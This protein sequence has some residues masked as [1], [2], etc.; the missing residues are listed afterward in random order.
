MKKLICTWLCVLIFGIV[1]VPAYAERPKVDLR[2]G[3]GML[4]GDT[5]YQIGGKIDTPLGS[6]EVHFP[7]SELKFPLDVYMA[8]VGGSIEFAEKWKVNASV[9]KN[10]TSDTGM[11]EDS[12]WGVWYLGAELPHMP[13]Y[14]CN[15]AYCEPDS[16]DI[17]SESGADLDA[18][19]MD[20][21]LRYKFYEKSNWS[22]SAGLGYIHQNF[23]YEVSNL[24]QWYPSYYDYFGVGLPYDLVSGKVLTYEV[25]YSIPYIELATEF[26]IKDKF[27]VGASI[28]YSP[29]VNVKDE[30]NHILRSKI[31]KGDCDGNAILLSLDGQYD[32]TESWFLTL[33][34]NYT[35]VDADGKSKSYFDGEYSHTIDRKSESKQILTTFAV[36]YAF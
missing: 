34:F 15:P 29:F 9:K 27:S 14:Y 31:S 23:D 20:I 10:I 32:F 3:I 12:D 36:G 26:K 5:T 19:I 1:G 21:N 24:V 17:Y 8:S 35:T 4:R 33:L 11:M 7:L 22:F 16:L 6:S 30:D 28:G 18:L 2:L 25:T 13:G